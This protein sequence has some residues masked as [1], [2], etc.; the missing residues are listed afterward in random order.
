MVDYFGT[1]K[2]V[3]L[4]DTDPKCSSVKCPRRLPENC[5]G[6]I[7]TG[8]CCPVCGGALKI[9]YSRK[10]IDRGIYAL[11]NSDLE[12]LTLKSILKSLQQMVDVSSCYLSGFLTFETDI[13]II[14]YTIEKNPNEDQVDVC[15]QEAIKI[16]NLISTKSH[17]FTSNLGLS[18]FI[19]A[20]Y[21]IPTVSSSVVIHTTYQVSLLML[22][23]TVLF[24]SR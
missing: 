10:Q 9:I 23:I 3:G 22:C 4:I 11:K 1:C 18:S 7:P 24:A 12:A 2:A 5:Y 8:A 21:V 20:R 19:L 6:I 14:V 16:A 17:H 13:M 15:Q